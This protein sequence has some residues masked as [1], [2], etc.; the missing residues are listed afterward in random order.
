MRKMGK[1]GYL[2]DFK[3]DLFSDILIITL[4]VETLAFFV[5]LVFFVKIH[6]SKFILLIKRKSCFCEIKDFSKH[7]NLFRDN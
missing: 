6:S 3:F 2:Q 5:F 1:I 4:R 7:K